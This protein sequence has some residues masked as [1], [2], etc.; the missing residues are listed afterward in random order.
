M[1]WY[2]QNT[3]EQIS[4]YLDDE[5]PKP[6]KELLENKIISSPELRAELQTG[7][8]VK[9]QLASLKRLPE[10]EYFSSRL[11]ERING[12]K[13]SDNLFSFIK[14]PMAAFGIITI[15]LMGILKLYPDLFPTFLSTQKTNFI[16]FYTQNLKPFIYVADLNSEDIFNFAF[17]NNLP[18]NKEDRQILQL[19]RDANGNQFVEVKYAGNTASVFNLPVFVKSL[20]LNN[21]QKHAVDSILLSYSDEIS[22]HILVNEKN[23]VAVSPSIWNAHNAIR[24]DLLSYVASVNKEVSDK[25]LPAAFS[26]NGASSYYKT[27]KTNEL[28]DDTYFVFCPDTVFSQKFHVNKEELIND[29]HN[30]KKEMMQQTAESH[31]AD[32]RTNKVK[33]FKIDV[34][35][36]PNE[37]TAS[38]KINVVIDSNVCRVQ[39]PQE[40]LVDDLFPN[41]DS[42]N[43]VLDEAFVQL[44]NF[45]VNVRVDGNERKDA[46]ESGDKR[47]QKNSKRFELN[48]KNGASVFQ[49]PDSLAD[50]FRFY[51]QDSSKTFKFNDK[52]NKDMEV[53]KKEMEKFKLDMEKMKKEFQNQ[54]KQNAAKEDPIEI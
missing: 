54:F 50:F 29:I 30:F 28:V 40:I 51:F 34:K 7:R 47:K 15:C 52:M 8:K 26:G 6:E 1:K 39:I 17:N 41:F 9:E 21:S 44:R 3:K 11:M 14:R 23:T 49:N 43:S 2:N 5:I 42:I 32:G 10:D 33:R 38:Q 35:V 19:D 25:I 18:L 53:F 4:A 20:K 31:R 22:S 27:K 45:Q 13:K 24:S 36:F 46:A 12:S 48:M 16:D 37:L